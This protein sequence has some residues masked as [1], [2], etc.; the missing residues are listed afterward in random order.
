VN[1][2][3]VGAACC[4]PSGPCIELADAAVR[5]DLDLFRYHPS[6]RDR[7]GFPV[8]VSRF[9]TD[10]VPDEQRGYDL[11]RA[12]VA[13]LA[14]QLDQKRLL[15]PAVHAWLV[16]PSPTSRPGI[17]DDLAVPLIDLLRQSWPDDALSQV[18]VVQGGHASGM[19][20]LTRARAYLEAEPEGQALVLGVESIYSGE[21]LTWFEC[22]HLLHGTRS[23]SH[24]STRTNPYGRVPGEGAA[25]IALMNQLPD[26]GRSAWA[27]LLGVGTADEPRTYASREPCIGAGL[28]QAAHAALSQCDQQMTGRI[29][30]IMLDLNDEPYRADQFGFT[31][32]RLARY[33]AS[34]WQRIVPVRASGDLHAVSA[35]AHVALAAYTLHH[36]PSRAHHLVLSS[37]DDAARG[38]ALL[39]AI[40]PHSV[41]PEIRTWRSPSTS[42][43]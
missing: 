20:A 12:V 19:V 13:E 6:Y 29:G 9:P 42:M 35:I 36:R 27:S 38:A 4:F 25:A 40:D 1:P 24:G 15:G 8:Q 41:L 34:F 26:G 30:S 39:G 14:T 31:A 43:T 10:D 5:A 7:C 17:P 2:F 11:L 32:L 23:P 28:T 33:M 22:Q 16:L 18:E 37:S 21:A 3:V